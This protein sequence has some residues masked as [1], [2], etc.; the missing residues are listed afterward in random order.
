MQPTF[1]DYLGIADIERIHSQTINWLLS[2]ENSILD[3][4]SKSTFLGR[5]FKIEEPIE[6]KNIKSDTEIARID[7]F[8]N[9]DKCQF[10]IENKLK[11]SEH[12]QTDKYKVPTQFKD[13]SKT[14]FSGFLTFIN[15]QPIN[16][17]WVAISFKDLSESLKTLKID[18]NHK[19]AIFLEEYSQ[20]IDNFVGIFNQ[21]MSNHEDFSTV[22]T[23]GSKKKSD[24]PKYDNELLDFIR[25]NQLETI[26][27]KAF[28]QAICSDFAE[29]INYKFNIGETHGTALIQ[30]E[31][32]EYEYESH[33]YQLGLQ[34]QGKSIKINFAAQDYGNSSKDQL[35]TNFISLFSEVFRS[36]NGFKRL[37]KPKTN[38]YLS[39]SK[40]TEKE[41]YEYSKEE[42]RAIIKDELGKIEALIP[43]FDNRLKKDR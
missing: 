14:V 35:D 41:I 8:I 2:L 4:Q 15:E 16:K 33:R 6:L 17:E 39:V 3:E 11:S 30:I 18:K 21:F 24:K 19:Q 10:L 23:D 38:A 26:F 37:N 40:Q 27:Q 5:L 36:K 22:F 29:S 25:R 31:M 32:K 13:S 28:L 42:I 7:I 9:S 12:H 34:I 20:T 1:F 43:I